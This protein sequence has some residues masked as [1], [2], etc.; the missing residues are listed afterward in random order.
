MKITIDAIDDV[1]FFL[2]DKTESF[3]C[4]YHKDSQEFRFINR[5][6]NWEVNLFNSESHVILTVDWK[7]FDESFNIVGHPITLGQ[8]TMIMDRRINEIYEV[9]TS[10]SFAKYV[11]LAGQIVHGRTNKSQSLEG[12]CISEELF[13]N[14][15]KMIWDFFDDPTPD[16][17]KITTKEDEEK[18]L[19]KILFPKWK[20]KWTKK[21][22]QN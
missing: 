13:N 21:S 17:Y 3:W 14:L 12:A 2:A 5:L 10:E 11:F 8:L 7:F 22:L 19:R 16:G 6:Q 20:K 4:I 1:Y 15:I 9:L 18:E